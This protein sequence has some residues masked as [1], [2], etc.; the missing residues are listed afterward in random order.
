MRAN[1]K[2]LHVHS[3]T[4]GINETRRNFSTSRLSDHLNPTTKWFVH[5]VLTS[6]GD[7]EQ[8][9]NP[10]VNLCTAKSQITWRGSEG[11][12]RYLQCA[13][14]SMWS[15]PH[16][17]SRDQSL[18]AEDRGQ[19]C[20]CLGLDLGVFLNGSLYL[21]RS[22]QGELWRCVCIVAVS[23]DCVCTGGIKVMCFACAWNLQ[24]Y[25]R[26]QNGQNVPRL[27]TRRSVCFWSR[28]EMLI[29]QGLQI[30]IK[31]SCHL[32]SY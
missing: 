25:C 26:E 2:L 18:A 24:D 19:W 27:E 4:T 20:L 6:Q 9:I 7:I 21:G 12:G 22:S 30:S 16:G 32:Y 3:C 10:K 14:N 31:V 1:V 15:W 8:P 5:T 29:I 17:P 23:P 13:K 28:S 11:V